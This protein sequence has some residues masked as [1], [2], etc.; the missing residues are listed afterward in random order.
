[1]SVGQPDGY[2][3][4]KMSQ[5]LG[6]LLCPW[7]SKEHYVTLC[8]AC[9]KCSNACQCGGRATKEGRT[10]MPANRG[11]GPPGKYNGHKTW[12]YWN[13]SLWIGN[14]EG[15]YEMA[16]ECIDTTESRPAAAEQMLRLLQQS[17]NTVVPE[18]PDGAYYSKDKI[19]SAMRGMTRGE[20]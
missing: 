9:R 12:A 16:Q 1:M 19:K 20:S 5:T 14:D 13:V 4:L 18:T 7:C 17:Q 15:L 3:R 6:K 8:V 2:D 11:Q 10:K